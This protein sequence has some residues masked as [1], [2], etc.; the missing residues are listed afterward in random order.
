MI[1]ILF[2]YICDFITK[3]RKDG[4]M[5]IS[6]AIADSNKEYL[7]RLVEVLQEYEELSV[8]VFTSAEKLEVALEKGRYDIVLFDPDISEKKL[9]FYNVKLWMCL[10]SEEAQNIAL[11]SECEK[12]IKY[13]RVSKIYKDV[14]K[15]YADKAGYL[16]TFDY[17]QNTKMIAVYSP[18]GGSGKTTIALALACKYA[19]QDENVLY[20]NT[21]QLDSSSC[22]DGHSREGDDITVLVEA[23]AEKSSFELK[24]KGIIKKGI[25]GI[26]YIEGFGR[27]VDYNTVT[28]VEIAE[29][30]E[31]IRKNG[32]FDT[33]ILDMNSSMDAINQ[34]I[35]EQ[36]DGIVIIDKPGDIESKKMEVFSQQAMTREYIGK[37]YKIH[38]LSD[39]RNKVNDYFDVPVLGIIRNY[40]EQSLKN[41]IHMIVAKETIQ[42][43]CVSKQTISI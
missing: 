1:E 29:I 28:K 27:F 43:N 2:S 40:G 39:K 5:N 22:L 3:V 4:K 7:K 9:N 26:S 33:V 31:N 37:M 11:Y 36:V 10:Y 19:A 21:E 42:L 17:S 8:A 18:I 32:E 13:Q 12:V 16:A 6:I 25:N 15:A 23:I 38:N 24:L 35:F 41:L 20:I 30:I 34:S 14:I